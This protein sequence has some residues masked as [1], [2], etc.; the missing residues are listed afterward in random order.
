MCKI[1]NQM[2]ALKG[3]LLPFSLWQFEDKPR[4]MIIFLT[5]RAYIYVLEKWM[6]EYK[7]FLLLLRLEFPELV[8]FQS[9]SPFFGIS[10]I[11]TKVILNCRCIYLRRDERCDHDRLEYPNLVAFHSISLIFVTLC[12]PTLY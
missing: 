7:N 8:T 10:L 5:R 2:L 12:D 6:C 4:R 9:T 3:A 1:Y 11:G